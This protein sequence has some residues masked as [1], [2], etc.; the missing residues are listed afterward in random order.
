MILALLPAALGTSGCATVFSGSKQEVRVSAYPEGAVTKVNGTVV[1]SP[2][3]QLDRDGSY[4]L[5]IEKEGHE[6]KR[7]HLKSG[8]NGWVFANLLW[9]P[10]FFVGLLVDALTGS[11]VDLEPSHASVILDPIVSPPA[12]A[13]APSP[14]RAI[15]APPA[16]EPPPAAAPPGAAL[17][18][19]M[20]SSPPPEAPPPSEAPLTPQKTR[21]SAGQTAWVLAVMDLQIS[22][23]RKHLED[24]TLVALTDQLRVYLA[25]RGLRVVDR[26]SQEAAMKALVQA[27]KKR[28]YATCVDTSCQIPLGKAL[29][30]S[31]ILRASTARFGGT[32]TV[33]GELVELRTEVTVAA[34][35]TRASCGEEDLLSAVEGLAEQ[36]V[37]AE[38]RGP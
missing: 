8:V 25:E 21:A 38:P 30:A 4:V 2:V 1:L 20:T 26:S 7:I 11:I 3:L 36:L 34:G 33:N 37:S 35:S 24:D 6:S 17:A 9:G 5:T 16:A 31:H 22:G 29:A 15:E 13:A 27:E 12:L 32:C 19:A 28:S 23:A 18:L 14:P 10:F